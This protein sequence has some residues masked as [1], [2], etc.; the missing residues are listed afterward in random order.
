MITPIKPE[1]YII[2]I[3]DYEITEIN[4]N[5]LEEL[6]NN[7]IPIKQFGRPVLISDK[8]FSSLEE[9]MAVAIQRSIADT[10]PK[11][12]SSGDEIKAALNRIKTG[13]DLPEFFMADNSSLFESFDCGHGAYVFYKI[14][15]D[16]K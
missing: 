13:E 11:Y 15:R 10:L 16:K 4:P 7:G 14:S 6:L 9:H 12:P 1:E 3:E 2:K 8:H 5:K